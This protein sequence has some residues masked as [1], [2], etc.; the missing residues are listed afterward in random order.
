[1]KRAPHVV[2]CEQSKPDPIIFGDK[3]LSDVTLVVEEQEF[4]AHKMVSLV[5]VICSIAFSSFLLLVL[6]FSKQC[7]MENS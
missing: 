6:M 1:M 4:I 3:S 2:L 7:S 5:S